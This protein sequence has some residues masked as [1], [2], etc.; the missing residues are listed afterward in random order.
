M[1]SNLGLIWFGMV[2]HIKGHDVAEVF[3]STV[4][5]TTSNHFALTG[6]RVLCVFW[7]AGVTSEYESILDP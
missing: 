4:V 7:E 1:S 3:D 5:P 2:V 6:T